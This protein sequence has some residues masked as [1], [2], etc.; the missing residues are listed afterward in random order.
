MQG[1]RQVRATVPDAVQVF[2]APPSPRDAAA[3][4]VGRGTDGPEDVERRLQT[5]RR[6]SWP[7]RR[8]S[9]YVVVNDRLEEAVERLEAIVR[10]NAGRRRTRG[11]YPVLMINPRIDR[12]LDNVDSNYA[13][14]IVA[15]KRARQINSYY[16][17][18]GEGTFDEFPPPMVETGVEEL[19]DDRPRRGRRGQAEVPATG[20][21]RGTAGE[22]TVARVLLGVSGGIAAYKALE[23]I[24]LAT[25]AGHAVRVV[26]TPTSRR[27]V[28]AASFAALSGAPV[29]TGEFERDPARGRLPRPGPARRT[30][31]SRHLELVRNADAYLIA[32]ASA[33]T[34]AKLAGGL[35]DNLLTSAALA[36][37]CPLVVAPAMNDAMWEHPATRGQRRDAARARRDGARARRRAPGLQGRGGRRAPARAGRA[38]GR[39]RGSARAREGAAGRPRRRWT[40]LRVLVTA[41]GTRE[42]IDAVRFVGNRSSGRMGFALADEAARRGA[43][44]T[45]VAA[46]VAL[47]RAT[48]VEIVAVETAAAAAGAR[49]TSTSTPATCC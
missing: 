36:A 23:L 43:E 40:G 28:G 18:L 39:G 47:P 44:V 32:P 49:A 42:P 24:R 22:G 10:E 25:A 33:N 2:I 19:P 35:A 17:N 16:H 20:R 34:I 9:R 12:L 31:R 1:A 7:R 5:A 4:L 48:G 14:V 41:G 46:N 29:L 45:V 30:T 15:A 27:F 21:A 38:A 6:R 37:R 11:H 8:S 13:S 3:R 26:Q